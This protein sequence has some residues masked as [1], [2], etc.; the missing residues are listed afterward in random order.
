[1]R[2]PRAPQRTRYGYKRSTPEKAEGRI[3]GNWPRMRLA[4]HPRQERRGSPPLKARPALFVE[5]GDALAPVLG[6]DHAVVGLDL[7]HHAA[8]QIHLQPEMDRV[9]CLAHGD[10][11][12]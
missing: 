11:R 10:R 8:R 7:E 12:V 1:M 2:A 3:S 6:R 5:R 4:T 9:L